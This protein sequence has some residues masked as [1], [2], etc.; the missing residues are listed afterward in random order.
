MVIIFILLTAIEIL[1]D[2][3]LTAPAAEQSIPPPNAAQFSQSLYHAVASNTNMGGQYS[4]DQPNDGFVGWPAELYHQGPTNPSDNGPIITP[5]SI[6]NQLVTQA[7]SV[8]VAVEDAAV[9]WAPSH[10]GE[11]DGLTFWVSRISGYPEEFLNRLNAFFPQHSR[12]SSYTSQRLRAND[13]M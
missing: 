7:Q 4:V 8:P 1:S 6:A 5:S 9:N 10:G 2:F 12:K 13:G 11:P 3:F